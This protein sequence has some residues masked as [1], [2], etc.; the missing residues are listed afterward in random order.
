MKNF[1]R[2]VI[3]EVIPKLPHNSLVAK[4]NAPYRSEVHNELLRKYAKK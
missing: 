1:P 4:G 3:H 2:W